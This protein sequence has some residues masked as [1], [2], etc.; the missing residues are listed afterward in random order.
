M[1]ICTGMEGQDVLNDR[2]D[3]LGGQMLTSYLRIAKV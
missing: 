3:L 1:I 2:F